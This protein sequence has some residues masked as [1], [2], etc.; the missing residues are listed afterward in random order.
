MIILHTHPEDYTETGSIIDGEYVAHSMCKGSSVPAETSTQVNLPSNIRALLPSITDAAQQQFAQGGPEVFTGQRLAGL[1]PFQQQALT[2]IGQQGLATSG[3]Q[4]AAEGQ[5]IGT[6][7]GEGFGGGFDQALEAA[8]RGLT[9]QFQEATLPGIRSAFTSAGRTG[10]SGL[11]ESAEGR[12]QQ[13]LATGIGDI[14]ANLAQAERGRQLQALALAPQTEQA[15]F[16]NLQRALA[17]GGQF[18]L[19]QQAQL[20]TAQ[21]V[22]EEQQGR[23][24]LALD[25][26]INRFGAAAAPFAGQTTQ[27]GPAGPGSNR[28]L[29]G[30]GGAASGAALGATIGAAG[31]PI[32]ALGGAAIGGLAGLFG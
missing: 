15:Q 2:Q 17:A 18:Q 29:T 1:D 4:G 8:T 11:L 22:F 27:I 7:Q 20:G 13:N 10:R 16:A 30:L 12:A 26:L 28:L 9:T 21:D 3:I 31:G 32:G 23:E 25:Q 24:G 14:S 19:Q 6:L 5:L